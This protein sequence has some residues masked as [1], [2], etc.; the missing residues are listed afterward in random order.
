MHTIGRFV[1]G[2]AA[3][4]SYQRSWLTPDLVAG[5]TVWA[6]LVPQALGY[7]SL[8]GLPTV[9]GLYAALGALLL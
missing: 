7:A 2:L 8:A 6:I 4:G 1:P 3:L 5:I 9:V